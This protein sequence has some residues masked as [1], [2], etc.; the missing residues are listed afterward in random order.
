MK[1]IAK[2][3]N[4]KY[5][6]ESAQPLAFFGNYRSEKGI[7][8]I[9]YATANG[10]IS[11]SAERIGKNKYSIAAEQHG[12]YTNTGLKKEINARFGL[13]D[14]MKIIYNNIET[15]KFMRDAVKNFYGMRVTLNGPWETALSFIVSQFNNIK[16][17]RGIMLR[18]IS[19]FGESNSGSSAKLFPTPE[20]ISKASI[21]QLKK[22]GVGFRAKYIKSA[23]HE[24]V[25]GSF[26]R[27][28]SMGYEEA[29]ETLMKYS[30][31]GDKV[32]DCILLMGYKKLEA[33]PIDT[34][35]ERILEK[36]YGSEMEKTKNGNIAIREMHRFAMSKWNSYAGYA[37]QYLYWHGRSIG[38]TE[39]KAMQR[40]KAA[41][42]E[43]INKS[44]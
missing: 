27:L 33:F 34:W 42:L 3:F 40:N 16:R 7:E 18:L 11:V 28:N 31:I 43:N 39:R 19:E 12:Y 32:A 13:K 1:I 6:V 8:Y 29:K 4:L 37:E 22:C 25:E 2:D 44:I 5:T 10:I 26:D 23:A 21:G 20:S 9:E 24:F 30:G 14:N 38:I 41:A 36:E 17:I 15:D 35:V